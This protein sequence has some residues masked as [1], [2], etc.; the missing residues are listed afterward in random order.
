[1]KIAQGLIKKE[2]MALK[3]LLRKINMF[4]ILKNLIHKIKLMKKINRS[5]R[6]LEIKRMRR[7]F[8][9][10]QQT[11]DKTQNQAYFPTKIKNKIILLAIWLNLMTILC[12]KTVKNKFLISLKMSF[13]EK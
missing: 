6:M 3:N 5:R 8:T 1:M 7:F 10:H 9:I 12:K 13:L 2:L 4:L 11:L